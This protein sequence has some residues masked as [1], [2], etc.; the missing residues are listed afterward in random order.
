MPSSVGNAAPM[1]AAGYVERAFA[2]L[3][4]TR[5]ERTAEIAAAARVL[6]DCVAAGGVV[7][8][9]GTGHSQAAVLEIA[10]RAGGL[11]PTNRISVP[12][13]VLYGGESPEVLADPLLERQPGLAARLYALA[14]PR[15]AD[16]FVIVSNSGVNNSVVEM[17]L[18]VKENGHPLVAVTSRQHTAAVP[19][20]HASGRKLADLADVVLDNGGPLGDGLLEL[21]NGARVC[22]GSTLSSVLLVQ[23]M[24]AEAMGLLTQAGIEPPVYLSANLPG[25][26]DRNLELDARY[27]GRLRRV[28]S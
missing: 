10:G 13:V 6:A 5:A 25:G 4:R 16:M 14:D 28:A 20:L 24:I 27:A 12:D 15:P 3:E 18:A 2:L 9:F 22:A 21:S 19:A 26:H 8:A 23:M 1:S 17:A 7:Q 11:V